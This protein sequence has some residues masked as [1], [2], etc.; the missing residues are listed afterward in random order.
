MDQESAREERAEQEDADA[1]EQHEPA[2]IDVREL[3]VEDAR[4]RGRQQV[5]GDDPR[6]EL[7]RAAQLADDARQ[8]HAHDG[9]VEGRR[10]R[11]PAGRRRGSPSCAD[12]T[13]AGRDRAPRGWLRRQGLT[14]LGTSH[15]MRRGV[16]ANLAVADGCR[17]LVAG[18]E[19]RPSV[20]RGAP[21]TGRPGEGGPGVEVRMRG[22][23]GRSDRGLRRLVAGS[24]GSLAMPAQMRRPPRMRKATPMRAVTE[25]DALPQLEAGGRG[26]TDPE[27]GEEAVHQAVPG[28]LASRPVERVRPVELGVV[29]VGDRD[30]VDARLEDGCLADGGGIP[31]AGGVMVVPSGTAT[32]MASTLSPSQYTGSVSTTVC[33]PLERVVR[34]GGHLVHVLGRRVRD[35]VVRDS[36]RLSSTG[37]F[38]SS[39]SRARMAAAPSVWPRSTSWPSSL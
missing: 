24:S 6:V 26:G 37:H 30:L 23:S 19:C 10:G 2:S 31:L 3:A 25:G 27:L 38:Q 17:R 39:L 22:W 16:G 35:R 20:A 32:G 33:V 29:A 8:G 1:E 9:L 14:R 21:D 11:R 7:V 36:A 28:L 15:G 12:A 5:A 4:D 13:A 18:P 34:D